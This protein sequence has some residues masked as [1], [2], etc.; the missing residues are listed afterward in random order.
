LYNSLTREKEELVPLRP[1]KLGVYVCGVTVYDLC[2]VGHARVYVVFDTIVRWLRRDHQVTYVRNFTD[3]DD[4]II[5]RANERGEDPITLASRFADEFHV[6]MGRLGVGPADVEPRVSTHMGEIVD[7]IGELEEKGFAYRVPTSS[8]VEGAGNDVYFRV[9]NMASSRYLQLSG[10]HLEDLQAGARVAVDERK[11]DPMDFALWKSAKP[12]EPSWAS[13]FGQGRPGWH[14]ECSAMSKK[15]LGVTFDLHGGGKDL[16]FPHHTN[17]IAQSECAHGEVMA[18]YWVHNGFINFNDEKMAKSVGNFFT[19]RE[20]WPYCT[21][22]ALRFFLLSTHY[23]G[24]VN[25]DVHSSCPVCN[26]ELSPQEQA[27]LVCNTCTARGTTPD[28]EPL[29][30]IT[31]EQLRSRVRFPN[32]EEAERRVQYLYQTMAR[33]ERVLASTPTQDGPSLEFAFSKPGAPFTPWA[34]FE[35][36]MNDDFNTPR[37]IAALNDVL[38]VA[39]LLVAG[40]EK[41]LIGNKLAPGVRALLLAECLRDI[42]AMGKVLGLGEAD[43]S[44]FLETQRALRLKAKGLS[45]DVIEGLLRERAEKKAAKDFAAA[46]AVRAKIVEMGIE[47]MDTPAGVEWSV[48]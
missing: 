47:V 45:A 35:A 31:N 36:G 16:I 6:D 37:A 46:D 11:E 10:R 42:K 30:P 22:E 24:D 5:R 41:E 13:P 32:L 33:I 34:D 23:R 15:H 26:A 4:K 40:R 20:L 8:S 17:E 44:P 7:F 1:G 2:H 38:R 19:I 27:D 48:I 25:F 12:G 18:R 21:G 3:V 29:L 43:A 28:G 14:I 9:K 39:N